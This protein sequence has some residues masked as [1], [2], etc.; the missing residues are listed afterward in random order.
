[1]TIA[2]KPRIRDSQPSDLAAVQYLLQR[3]GLPTADLTCAPDLQISM[4]EA[5]GRVVGLIGLERFGAGRLL[6]SLAVTPECRSRGLG[7]ELVAHLERNGHA[8]GIERLV[9]LTETAEGFF[10]GLG[11]VPIDRRNVPEAI[12]QSA[13]FRSLCPASAVCM[14]MPLLPQRVEVAHG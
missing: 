14:T 11:Y 12:K 7:H 8:A 1:M 5:E 2:L 9:L 13:E 10:R 3:A 6:R 4:L